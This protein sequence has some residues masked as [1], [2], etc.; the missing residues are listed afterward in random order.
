MRFASLVSLR[1]QYGDGLTLCRVG[2]RLQQFMVAPGVE[3]DDRSHR[4]VHKR[5]LPSEPWVGRLLASDC[6]APLVSRGKSL[7]AIKLLIDFFVQSTIQ[8]G[9]L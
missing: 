9:D 3:V 8:I 5:R 1:E 6:G 2:L 7:I 4:W